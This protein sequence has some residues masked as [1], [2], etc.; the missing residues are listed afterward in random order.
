VKLKRIV[1]IGVCAGAMAAIAVGQ[2]LIHY[3]GIVNVA[4][5]SQAGLPNGSIA[6]G[7]V[8]AIFGSGLGPAKG[9]QVSAYPLGATFSGVSITVVQ[10]ST[11]VNA[12]PLYVSSGQINALMPS[13]APVG[14][15]SLQVSYN[16]DKS[17]ASPVNVV[18]AS[19]GI[20]AANSAGSGPGILQNAS[21]TGQPINAP[22][23]TA[24][25]G[26]TMILWGTGLGP[27]PSDSVA[28]SV[29]NLA[30]MTEVFVGGVSAAVTYHGRSPCCSGIDQIVFQVPSNAPQGCWVPV[31]VRTG[32]ALISNVVSMAI[33]PAGATCSDPSNPT[34]KYIAR[35]GKVA[36]LHL[37]RSDVY[38]D[39]GTKTPV[40]VMDDFF[41]FDL[42]QFGS[43]P[44]AF[45]AVN[46]T[47]PPGTCTVYSGAGDVWHDP[48]LFPRTE[49][50]TALDP[51]TMSLNG[52]NGTHTLAPDVMGGQAVFFGSYAPFLAGLPNQLYLDP[53]AY[54]ISAPGGA[55]VGEFE[56]SLTLSQPIYWY[57]RQMYGS[58]DRTMDLPIGILA[59]V[60]TQYVA[61]LG[62]NVDLVTNSWA[63]FYCVVPPGQLVFSVPSAILSAIP[64]NR[65][66][67]FQS[68]S[69]LYLTN[70]LPANGTTFTAS[71]L[72]F[73]VAMAGYFMGKT[74]YFQ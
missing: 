41:G 36:S 11:T 65:P 67:P 34:S 46:A 42:L 38:E 50:I 68:K 7:S 74:V 14:M 10:G 24:K 64:A 61:V 26:E 35:G 8:F 63:A 13:N 72:D 48:S 71:G 43:L 33:D 51:G 9:T 39:V 59:P 58:I 57:E 53:G 6:Q 12:L 73:G 22:G 40:D 55:N 30:T 3:R 29:G 62:G 25:P 15:V 20:F 54:T 32:G 4:S 56:V 16:T 66:F 44:F 49:S 27:V 18:P 19:F 31:Y 45:N 70:I 47:P 60:A 23:V 28:P 5:Y 37:V 69:M 21:Q 52:P 1:G 17:N 2:P